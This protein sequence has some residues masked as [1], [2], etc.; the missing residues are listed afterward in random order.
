MDLRLR[1]HT[2]VIV[3]G[4]A[5]IG[6]AT[7]KLFAA[8]GACVALWDLDPRVEEI[9][10]QIEAQFGV[11][12]LGLTVDISQ[13]DSVARAKARTLDRFKT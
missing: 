5:G 13:E 8:E 6:L 7:A 2:A 11:D 1:E 3:G 10:G 4:A 12:T 9:A